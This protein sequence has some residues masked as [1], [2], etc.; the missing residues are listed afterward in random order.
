[1]PDKNALEEE[2]VREAK[3][4]HHQQLAVEEDPSFTRVESSSSSEVPAA[5]AL[6]ESSVPEDVNVD[7]EDAQSDLRQF[8]SPARFMIALCDNI[9]TLYVLSI[10]QMEPQ[11]MIIT[12]DPHW[13]NQ[14]K[15]S[16]LLRGIH[17]CSKTSILRNES[18]IIKL[19]HNS[20]KHFYCR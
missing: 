14:S 13:T 16:I 10:I 18:L 9:R 12:C 4:M 17:I 8:Q 5:V 11:H 2:E 3:D 19:A 7:I 1:M 20:N 6:P 15:Q